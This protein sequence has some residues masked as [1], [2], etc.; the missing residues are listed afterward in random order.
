[1]EEIIILDISKL[2]ITSQPI[3]EAREEDKGKLCESIKELGLLYPLI[4]RPIDKD[5]YEVLDGRTRLDVLR[6]LNYKNVKCI[7]RRG[8]EVKDEVVPYDV[9]LYRRHLSSEEIQNFEEIRSEKKNEAESASMTHLISRLPFK[10]RKRAEKFVDTIPL[11]SKRRCLE[12][13]STMAELDL[14]DYLELATLKDERDRLR[15]KTEALQEEMAVLNDKKEKEVEKRCEKF[16]KKMEQ[17]MTKIEETGIKIP[18]DPEE[19]TILMKQIEAAVRMEMEEKFD[20][21]EKSLE[22]NKKLYSDLLKK[23][24]EKDTKI[25][26]LIRKNK[27]LDDHLGM[28]DDVRQHFNL[29]LHKSL[30]VQPMLNKIRTMHDDLDAFS[31]R[32]LEWHNRP[33][34]SGRGTFEEMTKENVYLLTQEIKGIYKKGDEILDLLKTT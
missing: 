13:L 27:D 10:L 28:I 6:D 23:T 14:R 22:K 2:I 5:N 4:V 34:V 7:V 25:E 3:K 11:G 8:E 26:T 24:S 32:L 17:R 18:E 12:F 19:K 9:E 30:G 21:V 29:I 15:A 31:G 16:A 1:V 33:M 20:D